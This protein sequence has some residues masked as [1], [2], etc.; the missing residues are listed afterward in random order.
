MSKRDFYD[1]LGVSK[2][3]DEKTLKAAYRKLAMANHPDRNQGD[4]AAEERFREA[5]EAYEVLKDP[6][7]RAAYDRM[8]HAAFDQSAGGFGGGGFGGGG[9]GGGGFADIFDQMF[10]E[11]SGGAGGGR[12]RNSGGND[13]RYD[14]TVSLE[15]AFKG[16]QED[17]SITV[18]ASCDSCSGSG[19][20]D[21]AKPSTCG[22]CGGSGRVR[23]QQGFFAVERT[24]HACQGM[25]QIISDPCRNCGGEG[26]VQRNKTLSVSIPAGVDTG[27]R[28]RLSGKGEAGVRGGPAGDLYIFVTVSPHPIFTRDGNN[29]YTKIP[30]PMTVAAL[31]DKIEV[32]TIEGKL[33]R[34]SIEA[35]TQ[36]GRQFRMRGKGMPALRRGTVGDQIVEVQVETPTNLSKKQKDLLQSFAEAGNAS[37][38]SDSFIERVKRIWADN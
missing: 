21:G 20:A 28:I 35:G 22:T 18:P 27:T 36:S 32:P 38:E 8:G 10:S 15:D 16:L 4:A 34:L 37:P 19:A 7:K 11:F 24:C 5:S 14:M 23:A 29:L 9:F 1:V 30:V 13:L 33:A 3:A 17:I 6:Q 26:R 31:G 12:Q 2:D 25:G